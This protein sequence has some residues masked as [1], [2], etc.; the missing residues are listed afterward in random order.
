MQ[1]VQEDPNLVEDQTRKRESTESAS[2]TDS[3]SSHTSDQSNA[4]SS[5]SMESSPTST[6]KNSTAPHDVSIKIDAPEPKIITTSSLFWVPADQH[7]EIA[8]TEF[9][10]WLREH[11]YLNIDSKRPLRRK[12]SIL[13]R[14]VRP[15]AEDDEEEEKEDR[16]KSKAPQLPS[17]PDRPSYEND[18]VHLYDIDNLTSESA[19]LVNILRRSLSMQLPAEST[20]EPTSEAIDT[21]DR[22]SSPDA[23][24]RVIVPRTEGGTLLKR[25][26]ATKIR[27]RS[28]ASPDGETLRRWSR[29][30]SRSI[31]PVAD[32]RIGG[33]GGMHA[34][35]DA[36]EK[37][38]EEKEE[39]K[40]NVSPP[41][42]QSTSIKTKTD[43]QVMPPS[44]FVSRLKQPDPPVIHLGPD[45]T[46]EKEN[47]KDAA[48]SSP[49]ALDM[50]LSVPTVA[51]SSITTPAPAPAPAIVPTLVSTNATGPASAPAS[52][53]PA[54]ANRHS[55]TAPVT[56]ERPKSP[57]SHKKSW[58]P[59]TSEEKDSKSKKPKDEKE[60]GH[61]EASENKRQSKL[62]LLFSLTSSKPRS[63]EVSTTAINK[64]LDKNLRKQINTTSPF[65][66]RLPLHVERAIYRLSHYKLSNPRRPLLHQVLI[67]NFMFW[68]LSVANQQPVRGAKPAANGAGGARGG[69]TA[70]RGGNS[71]ASKMRSKSPMRMETTGAGGGRSKEISNAPR[72]YPSPRHLGDSGSR[73][74]V[75]ILQTPSSPYARGRSPSPDPSRK[76]TNVHSNH[77]EESDDE[78]DEDDEAED[79]P[80]EH[81]NEQKRRVSVNDPNGGHVDN[82]N[83]KASMD[84]KSVSRTSMP[85]PGKKPNAVPQMKQPVR[86]RLVNT[87]SR[88]SGAKSGR[89]EDDDDMPLAIYRKQENSRTKT[90]Y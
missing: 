59:F 24:S 41:G 25:S 60:K 21:F 37:N 15:S 75:G 61:T 5:S 68:Y 88:P 11:G 48:E 32:K 55:L 22:F 31:S 9:A 35:T 67:S 90:R 86:P 39:P 84:R 49:A 56:L 58:W 83:G 87:S 1:S 89:V 8:P 42:D 73:Q 50:P 28:T 80:E 17:I 26:Q 23:N 77:T 7:P 63:T 72:S 65:V 13:S 66:C 53:A 19:A 76:R 45:R 30:R 2:S 64:P 70:A 10:N 40:E 6:S 51:P 20:L 78:D 29:R 82:G 4:S 54:S 74:V 3:N 62:S 69:G 38:A 16:N 81:S 57:T 44:P 33:A 36:I 14:Q 71:N 34:S 47:E 18:G 79:S 46:E 27:R 52:V 85:P 12:K 43:Q